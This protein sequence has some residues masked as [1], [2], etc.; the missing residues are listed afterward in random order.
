MRKLN[1]Q[2]G[3]FEHTY[4]SVVSD[5]IFD[6]RSSDG[7]NLQFIK[8][9]YGD[10]LSIPVKIGYRITIEGSEQYSAL[11]RYFGIMGG[12]GVFRVSEFVSQ[13]NKQILLGYIQ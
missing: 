9:G 3:T 11:I 8:R 2:I 13:L 10:V 5:V 7:W 6:T 1:V 12:K 4:N